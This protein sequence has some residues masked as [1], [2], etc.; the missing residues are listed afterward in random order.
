MSR[1]K[2]LVVAIL[3]VA[4]VAACA[5]V[6]PRT[7]APEGG[8]RTTKAIALEN[9]IKRF[10]MDT[11]KIRALIWLD[12]SDGETNR[13]TNAALVI[14]RPVSVRV[15]AID[16]LAD[17]WAQAASNGEQLWLYL[18]STSK[19]Y[20]GRASRRNLHRLMKFD[21]DIPEI[22]SAITGSPP[23]A[24]NK[25]LFQTGP[26]KDGHFFEGGGR[27]HI[28]VDMRSGRL[29]RFARYSDNGATLSYMVTCSDWRNADGVDFPHRIEATFP[30]RRARM[31]I[32][33]H[34]VSLGGE[35]DPKSFLPPAV[36][37]RS[38]I[39]LKDDR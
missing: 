8:A 10:V 37:R 9:H 34:E 24:D 28:W 16:E 39:E 6:P 33:Y 7:A 18:P 2:S 27:F 12:I 17:V 19:L 31:V 38:V 36:H 30:G 23:L 32:V 13:Q 5:K 29:Q 22:V 14:R 1:E 25:E 20:S 35:I 11:A 26:V 3:F 15:D 4:S 21:M